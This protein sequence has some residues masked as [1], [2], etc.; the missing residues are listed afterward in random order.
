MVIQDLH[1]NVECVGEGQAVILLHG[2]GQNMYMMKFIQY[3]LSNNYRVLNLD[4]PGFGKSEEPHQI[5]SIW[6]YANFLTH[7]L[8]AYHIKNPIIIAHSFGARIAIAYALHHSCKAL[9]LTGAAGILP[10]RTVRYYQ[11][12]WTYKLLKRLHI[13]LHMGSQD[14]QAASS[15]MKG[16]LVSCVN[17]DLQPYLS[18]LSCKTLL[19]WGEKDQQT[20]MWMGQKMKE[21]I[22]NAS[23]VV[24]R[25]EGHF[26]Y[27]HQSLRFQGVID[28]FFKEESL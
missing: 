5:W 6:D 10:K 28:H 22:P 9:V 13:P 20:P 3:H 19:V 2:W 25:N 15:I 14:Y 11:K 24:F 16:V 8:E 26:A 18:K 27:F 7:L 23:L 1:V 21:E 12:V 17:E 4:L